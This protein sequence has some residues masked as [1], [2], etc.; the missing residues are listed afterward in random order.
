MLKNDY[1][2]NID[3][4]ISMVEILLISFNNELNEL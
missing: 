1:F 4:F 3:K 2:K